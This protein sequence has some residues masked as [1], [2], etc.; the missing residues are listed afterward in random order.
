MPA[1]QAAPDLAK[2]RLVAARTSAL[3]AEIATLNQE[4]ATF[5]ARVE[6]RETQ[7]TAALNQLEVQNRALR[8]LETASDERRMS[9]AEQAETTAGAVRQNAAGK[10]PVFVN[11]ICRRRP[12][13]QS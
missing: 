3:N 4:I 9:A 13:N 5:T 11:L 1:V 2:L 6:L 7:R 12:I 8:L 10:H